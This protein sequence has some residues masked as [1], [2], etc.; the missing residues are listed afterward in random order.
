MIFPGSSKG[1][2]TA[3]NE[4][5]KLT[6]LQFIMKFSSYYVFSLCSVSNPLVAY[7]SRFVP[8]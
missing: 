6:P 5:F 3:S 2:H 8:M 1:T 7:T 4:I